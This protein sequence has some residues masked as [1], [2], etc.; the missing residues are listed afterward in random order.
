MRRGAAPHREISSARGGTTCR[1]PRRGE[2][3]RPRDGAGSRDWGGLGRIPERR[4]ARGAP[5]SARSR[6]AFAA[7][8]QY[9]ICTAAVLLRRWRSGGGL[10]RDRRVCERA[11]IRIG[12]TGTDTGV[13]KTVVTCAIAAALRRR[14]LRVAAMK[15]VETGAAFNAPERDGYR[16]RA[17]SED[18]R[19]ISVTAPLA[20]PDP[21]APLVAARYAGT[22][23]DIDR[24]DA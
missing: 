7:A 4:G 22:S 12:V 10:R 9:H 14:G 5:R 1:G 13:G 11:M 8:G 24:L 16:L 2:R 20:F 19:P 18:D 23:I 3:P 6:R 17:A 21:V 15:P